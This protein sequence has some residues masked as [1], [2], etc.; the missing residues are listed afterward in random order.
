MRSISNLV[1]KILES[2]YYIEIQKKSYGHFLII[3]NKTIISNNIG[4]ILRNEGFNFRYCYVNSN[5]ESIYIFT[6]KYSV[7]NMLKKEMKN[8]YNIYIKY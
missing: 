6:K 7:W 1:E 5:G 8:K 3:R 2:G 4:I